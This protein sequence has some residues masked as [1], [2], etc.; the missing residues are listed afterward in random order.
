[1]DA[2]NGKRTE[3]E[4]WNDI[5][6]SLVRDLE[7]KGIM[8]RYNISHLKLWTDMIYEGFLSG[9]GEEP[10]WEDHLEIVRVPPKSRRS[11]VNPSNSSLS[12]NSSNNSS[13]NG[14]FSTSTATNTNVMELLML[15][16]QQRIEMEAKK[17]DMFQTTLLAL[18]SSN[19]RSMVGVVDI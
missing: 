12:C 14:S 11:N 16:N 15:Q 9:I 17:A 4:L 13:F 2:A 8:W 3:N 18:V 5:H 10:M 1:M 7:K 19:Q 6:V